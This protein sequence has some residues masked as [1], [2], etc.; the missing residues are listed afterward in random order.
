MKSEWKNINTWIF[1]LDNTLYPSSSNL[2]AQIRERMTIFIAQRLDISRQTAYA[3]QKYYFQKYG[4][5]YR[6][7][8]IE[9]GVDPDEYFQFVHAVDLRVL[10]IDPLLDQ[11]LLRLSGRKL[12]HT[13]A[14]N[15]HAQNVLK[16]LK[17]AHHFSGVHDIFTSHFIPKPYLSAYHGLIERFQIDSQK[18]CMIEDLVC[19]LLP[20]SQL[21]MKTILVQPHSKLSD[22]PQEHVDMTVE[23]LT[24]G[25]VALLEAS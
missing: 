24:T 16:Y 9:H 20:S 15:A 2:F 22:Q 1:D 6:G 10:S 14:T 4:T 8:M 17:I 12:I 3:W 7:L 18:A 25:L 11:T 13:N 21:G 23:C 19:N 5:T